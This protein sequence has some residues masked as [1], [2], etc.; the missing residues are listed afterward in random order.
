MD[1]GQVVINSYPGLSESD[2]F[3]I[4]RPI[5]YQLIILSPLY[6]ANCDPVL[7]VTPNS[8]PCRL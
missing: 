2:A 4:I 3:K 5:F 6:A 1:Q 7:F 8:Q